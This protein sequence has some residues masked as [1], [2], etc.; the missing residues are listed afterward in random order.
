M[1]KT[2]ISDFTVAARAALYWRYVAISIRSQLQYRASFMMMAFG[3]LFATGIEAAGIW[4]L[5]ARFGTLRGWTLPQVALFYGVIGTG[6]ALAEGIG[7]GFDAFAPL[8]KSGDFDRLLLRP[9]STA[10]QVA[11]TEVQLMRVGRLIQAVCVLAWAAHALH[12]N[13]SLAKVVLLLGTVAGGACLFYGLFVVEATLAFWTVESLEIMNTVTYGGTE[14]G[15]YPLTIYRRGFR[16][17]FT[18][19]VPLACINYVPL[20]AILHRAELSY[21]A[22][23][24]S[25]SAPTV[26]LLFLLGSLQLWKFGVRHYCSTGS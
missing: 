23:W 5:F 13:W 25:W 18:Y 10:F 9:H 6:F 16:A 20:N 1:S 24:L 7:R 3:H 21:I 2:N 12:V 19:V 15:Q 4:A 26:G 14:T 17:F 11:A 8:V 22:P